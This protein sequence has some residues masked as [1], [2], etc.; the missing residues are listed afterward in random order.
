M[1][2]FRCF[3]LKELSLGAAIINLYRMCLPMVRCDWV[4]VG[5]S[6]LG[7]EFMDSCSASPIQS[8]KTDCVYQSIAR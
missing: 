3:M 1:H 5:M 7:S 4:C 8:K 2:T 6:S